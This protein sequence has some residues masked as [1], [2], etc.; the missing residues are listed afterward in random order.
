MK[1]VLRFLIADVRIT[2]RTELALRFTMVGLL[3]GA[4]GFLLIL[5]VPLARYGEITLLEPNAI[6]RHIEVVFLCTA[7]CFAL[8]MGVFWARRG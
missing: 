8:W 6:V 7:M 4:V 1:R 2:K 5:Y 3:V